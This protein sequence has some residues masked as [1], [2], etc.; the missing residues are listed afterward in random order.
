MCNTHTTSSRSLS[1]LSSLCS[2]CFAS[3]RFAS[4]RFAQT[5]RIDDIGEST[6]LLPDG[7]CAHGY[8]VPDRTNTKCVF[9]AR[10]DIGRHYILS[11]GRGGLKEPYEKLVSRMSSFNKFLFTEDRSLND[12]PELDTLFESEG[13]KTSA[14]GVCALGVPNPH[15]EPFQLAIIVQIPG[16]VV[17]MH[18]DAPWFWGADRFDFPIWLLV[19]MQ[20]SEL[21][22]DRR[23]HQVQGVAYIH[24]WPES[25]NNGGGFFYYPEG[26]GGPVKVFDATRRAG[27]ILDGSKQVHGTD[28]FRP[29]DTDIPVLDR[30]EK[31]ALVF[32]GNHTWDVVTRS[33]KTVATYASSDLRMSL[34]WRGL[35]FVDQA[36]RDAWKAHQKDIHLD[37]ILATFV[38]DLRSKGL[39]APSSPDP[40][41]L[42]LA[43]MIMDHYVL[44]PFPRGSWLP[45]NYCA[46]PKLIPTFLQPALSFLLSPLC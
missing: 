25:V 22:E 33:N 9:P 31:N 35:C 12:M 2:L 19:A 13:Y 37:D 18:F 28:A 20:W 3:L 27:I 4:L 21:W 34:V 23:I 15:I 17:P 1:S 41:G 40:T 29:D 44:Y 7:R 24:D 8:M 26:P 45:Y 10:L 14:A 16:Q 39:I 6:P 36:E 38:T 42:D 30:A 46:L 43:L 32:R 11:G 5:S